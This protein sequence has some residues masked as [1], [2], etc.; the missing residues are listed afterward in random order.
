MARSAAL[1]PK[2]RTAI[3]AIA[4]RLRTAGKPKPLLLTGNSARTAAEAIAGE[5]RLEIYRVDVSVILSKYIGETEKNIA[6]VFDEA[7]GSDGLLLFDEADALFGKR[8]EVK[9][10]HDRY[11]NIAISYLLERIEAHRAIVILVTQSLRP[12]PAAQRGRLSVRQFPPPSIR[13]A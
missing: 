5:L 9:D 2:D 10:A 6:R 7:E 3:R 12:L 1:R 8:T 13:P 11:A 4:A